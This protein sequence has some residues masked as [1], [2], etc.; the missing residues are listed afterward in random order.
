MIRVCVGWRNGR[1]VG[2][3]LTI[4]FAACLAGGAG[5]SGGSRDP[6]VFQPPVPVTLAWDQP[7]GALLIRVDEPTVRLQLEPGSHRVE[8]TA[9]NEAG[10][11]PATPVMVEYRDGRWTLWPIPSTDAG[12]GAA[13][14]GRRP[15]Q[16]SPYADPPR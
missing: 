7:D 13:P 15:E 10:C 5:C 16:R 6:S 11:S 9:C 3:Q 12:S 8:I 1:I 4:A 2:P 14:L